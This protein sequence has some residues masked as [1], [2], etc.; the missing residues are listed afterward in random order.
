LIITYDSAVPLIVFPCA[1]VAQSLTLT[2]TGA[3]QLLGTSG[4]GIA[5]FLLHRFKRHFIWSFGANPPPDAVLS[6]WDLAPFAWLVNPEWAVMNECPRRRFET[7]PLRRGKFNG[8]LDMVAQR[9]DR[10]AIFA[11]FASRLKAK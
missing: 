2:S 4:E 5:G 8:Y 6:I 1:D 9:L 3:G 10:E 7:N 11:D